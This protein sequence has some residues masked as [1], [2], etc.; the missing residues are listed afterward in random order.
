MVLDFLSFYFPSR[1]H[2]LSGQTEA[3]VV[4]DAV[5]IFAAALRELDNSEEITTSP[6]NCKHPSQWAHGMRIINYMKLVREN[7]YH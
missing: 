1:F 3:T 2:H 5:Q 6:M 4:S 7:L